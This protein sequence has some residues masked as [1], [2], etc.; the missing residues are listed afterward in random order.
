MSEIKRM[1]RKIKE[2]PISSAS[3]NTSV[4]KSKDNRTAGTLLR[5]SPHCS[6][7]TSRGK[8]ISGGAISSSKETSSFPVANIFQHPFN[9]LITMIEIVPSRFSFAGS[10]SAQPTQ[11]FFV[12]L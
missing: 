12:T 2:A 9:C 4:E 6:P 10:G 5:R 8:A 7:V 3:S 11:N 1:V